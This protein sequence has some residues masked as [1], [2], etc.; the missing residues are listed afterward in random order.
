MRPSDVRKQAL[1]NKKKKVGVF[2]PT[3][4]DFTAQFN[5]KDYTVPKGE[6]V[7]FRYHIA[8]H[9]AKHLADKVLTKKGFSVT[10]EPVRTKTLKEILV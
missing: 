5:G 1:A 2:N 6:M 10:Q 7:K 8:H 9:V 4:K 3:T